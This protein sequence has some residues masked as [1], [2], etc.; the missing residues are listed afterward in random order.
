MEVRGART[1][2]EVTQANAVMAR[3]QELSTRVGA[4]WLRTFGATY[5]RFR[6]EHTRI[7]FID[8]RIAGALRM[9]TYT[10]RIGAA[11]LKCGGLGWVSTDTRC[12][13]R[14]VCR[15]LMEDVH[16]YMEG[17]G[18]ALCMLFG[19]PE[20]YERFGYVSSIAD[21]HVAISR[22]EALRA[23]GQSLRERAMRKTDIA[24]TLRLHNAHEGAA[25]CSLVRTAAN[26]A[27]QYG[28]RAPLSGLWWDWPAARML[29]D[30]RGR[31]R[32]YYLPQV[33]GDTLHI[34]ETAVANAEACEAVMHAA[35][36]TAKRIGA[37]QIHFHQP[38][39]HP[40]VEHL[41]QYNCT[42][43]SSYYR[44]RD[45]M[46]RA[47]DLAA[48]LHG[49]ESEWQSQHAGAV[50]LGVAGVRYRISADGAP[51]S[52]KARPTVLMSSQEF[53][54]L[55]TGYRGAASVLGARYAELTARHQAALDT[56]FPQRHPHVWPMDHF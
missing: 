31:V 47:I 56:R 45:G 29:T 43:Q 50:V 49:M 5:P 18:Y 44:N 41:R 1:A 42:Q 10:V 8:G 30:A 51:A 33:N 24:T 52:T 22:E 27:N 54:Q 21:H 23:K 36:R 48:A 25:S 34:K 20:F 40:M 55:L 11:R 6:R 4:E 13:G 17:H 16:A 15:A 2:D 28:S 3:A 12:R 53:V 39:H 32:A 26:I 46:V 19:I 7:A 35:A 37:K 38:P 9:H 14:G